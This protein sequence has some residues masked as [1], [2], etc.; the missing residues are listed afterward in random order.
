MILIE[1]HWIS[2]SSILWLTVYFPFAD[3]FKPESLDSTKSSTVTI[4]ENNSVTA[5]VP[6]VQVGAHFTFKDPYYLEGHFA[7]GKII[8]ESKLSV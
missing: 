2:D 7:H 4:G 5:I 6:H 3:D 1:S 8:T